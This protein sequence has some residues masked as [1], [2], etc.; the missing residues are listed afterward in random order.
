ME[1]LFPTIEK[2]ALSKP[3][4]Y[5]PANLY[6]YIDGA[7]DAFLQQ[8]FQE[9]TTAEYVNAEKVVVTVDVYRHRDATRAF[10]MHT[11]ERSTKAI[12]LALGVEGTGGD[13]HL[14]F[15]VGSYYVKITQTGGK[16]TRA[17]EAIA[18]R[19]ADALPGTREPPPTVKCFP[20]R[21]KVPRAEKLSARD[22]LGHAFLHDGT[23]AP[24]EIAGAHFRMFV[25]E[26][27]ATADAQQ[28]LSRYLA[29]AKSAVAASPQG[30]ATLRDP[31][32]GEVELAW[33]GRWLWGAVDEPSKDR[34]GL[35]RELGRNIEGCS[36]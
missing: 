30:S 5:S 17:F 33:K 21:G 6:E 31:F 7:A 11:Q 2:W 26:G 36:Q 10:A 29:L 35:V 32:N 3:E 13:D 15:V 34:D 9:L 25:I 8:D 28:M 16:G 24:Y 27:R 18:K 19:M 12:P 4:K 20:E 23:T 22:F 14:E 1:S